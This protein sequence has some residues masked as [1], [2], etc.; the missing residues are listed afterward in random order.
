MTARR[1]LKWGGAAIAALALLATLGSYDARAG[2]FNPK[3]EITVTDPTP[4][5]NSDLSVAFGIPEGDVMFAGA[6]TFYPSDWGIVKG[7]VIP[8]TGMSATTPPN[9]TA[10]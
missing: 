5:A 9:I 3:L 8:V 2:T 1:I 7:S 10:R 4:E 6:V